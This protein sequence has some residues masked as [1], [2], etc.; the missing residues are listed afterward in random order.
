MHVE[1]QDVEMRQRKFAWL[2][3]AGDLNANGTHNKNCC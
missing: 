2:V 1:S 3:L